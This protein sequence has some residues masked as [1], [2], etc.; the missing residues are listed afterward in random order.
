MSPRTV[1]GWVLEQTLG[2]LV[3]ALHRAQLIRAVHITMSGRA[4][5]IWQ[6]TVEEAEDIN[7][8]TGLG[9]LRQLLGDSDCGLVRF[10]VAQG[11]DI[12]AIRACMESL[13]P[14]ADAHTGYDSALAVLLR[15]SYEVVPVE[16]V[17]G[18]RDRRQTLHTIHFLWGFVADRSAVGTA[19]GDAC[20][21][22]ARLSRGSEV[23]T[24]WYDAG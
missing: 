22:A 8:V 13:A 7:S 3:R 10:L 15:R 5:A 16:A 19:L 11:A 21:F 1:V 9:L 20:P 4:A 17:P 2:R 23:W 14:T 24:R 12:G 6:A 18:Q